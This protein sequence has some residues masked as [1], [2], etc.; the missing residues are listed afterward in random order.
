MSESLKGRGPPNATS[1]LL[2]ASAVAILQ[3]SLF[4]RGWRIPQWWEL[5]NNKAPPLILQPWSFFVSCQLLWMCRVADGEY[6]QDESSPRT[7]SPGIAAMLVSRIT[8]GVGGASS[9]TAFTSSFCAQRGH[10]LF[11]HSPDIFESGAL[12]SFIPQL[13]P[14]NQGQAAFWNLGTFE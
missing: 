3:N 12:F 5:P 10:C 6:C 13:H 9:I 11:Q 8:Q 2:E 1:S 14:L 7:S 4:H